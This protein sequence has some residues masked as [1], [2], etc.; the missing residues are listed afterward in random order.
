MKH[1]SIRAHMTPTPHTIGRDQTLAFAHALMRTHQI[2][3]LPVLTGGKLVGI[4]SDR[5]LRFIESLKD[6]DPQRVL[7][8]EAMTQEPYTVA[9]TAPLGEVVRTM[10]ENRYGAALVVD[11]GHVIGIF[12]AV[13]ALRVLADVLQ[14]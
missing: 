7:V 6:V 13:D 2:R 9:S 5:D 11:E 8:E 10:A 1:T 3:H 14:K 4:V 12:T